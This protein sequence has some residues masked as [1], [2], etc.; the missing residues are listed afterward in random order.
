MAKKFVG[1]FHDQSSLEQKMHALKEQ[2]HKD[3]DFSVVGR[4]EAAEETSGASWVDEMK[5]KF[6]KEPPLRETLKR[7]GHSDDEAAKH[8]EEVERGGIALFV[9][10]REHH[11]HD[12]SHDHDRE[13]MH[14]EGHRHEGKVENPGVNDYESEHESDHEKST[15]TKWDADDLNK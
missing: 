4:D 11:D 15:R 1:V 13:H 5:A 12:H 9:K 8:Y 10:E 2:G 3:S 7:V 14:D 6:S